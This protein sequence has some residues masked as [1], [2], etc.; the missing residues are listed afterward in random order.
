MVAADAINV[1]FFSV[2]LFSR[3]PIIP[4]CRLLDAQ[5]F[6][7]AWFGNKLKSLFLGVV[8]FYVADFTPDLP[9]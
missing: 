6:A 5:I 4:S 3:S 2:V 9:K 7:Q 1:R 8:F